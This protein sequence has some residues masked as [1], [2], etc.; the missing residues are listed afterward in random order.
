MHAFAQ[1]SRTA[2]LHKWDELNA[3]AV[4]RRAHLQAAH[5]YFKCRLLVLVGL[6]EALILSEYRFVKECDA[7][8]VWIKDKTAIATEDNYSD[9]LDLDRKI[10]LHQVRECMHLR[11]CVLARVC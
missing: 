2:A 5:D 1:A 4:T 6:N 8:G 9:H 3:A 11:T 10:E 7:M